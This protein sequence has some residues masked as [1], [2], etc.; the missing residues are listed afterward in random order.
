[1]FLLSSKHLN[2]FQI[3]H[4][5]D[6]Q[7]FNNYDDIISIGI[8][9]GIEI[10]QSKNWQCGDFPKVCVNEKKNNYRIINK[11]NYKIF[12]SDKI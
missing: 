7:K 6:N 5:I 4:L 3:K 11:Y 12:L 9:D 2:K 10:F 8:F 1:M